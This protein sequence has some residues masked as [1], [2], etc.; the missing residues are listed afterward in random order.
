MMIEK[1]IEWVN[2]IILKIG[3]AGIIFFMFL[4]STMVPIPSEIIM[5]FAGYLAAQRKMNFLLVVLTSGI[6]SLLGSIFSY[7]L[8]YYGGRH[9][10]K[11]IGK[12]V[13]LDEKR[14]RWTE[15]WFKKN[16][17]KTIFIARFIP[18]VRHLI[19]MPAGIGK[20]NILKF[21]IYTFTG[22]IIWN[23]IL[24]YM[25]LYL[26]ANYFIIHEYSKIIDWIVL[27]ALIASITYYIW[28]FSVVTKR[29]K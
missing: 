21:C 2:L 14:L 20:M 11:N 24:T 27:F 1:I 5:P 26:G 17:E 29:K 25:G 4:E 9:F 18:V 10:I 22:A 3:Y 16:G 6:G 13:F 12:Y 23:G 7:Y 28:R 8:G 15:N 19:S